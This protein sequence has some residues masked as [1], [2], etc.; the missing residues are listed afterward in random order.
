MITGVTGSLLS[1]AFLEAHVGAQNP[2]SPLVLRRALVAWH[3]R[4]ASL[5][6]ASSLRSMFESGARPLLRHLGYQQVS[7]IDPIDRGLAA[8]LHREARA[9]ALVVVA[10]GE[11]FDST[12]RLAI[13]EAWRRST[14]YALMF[15]GIRLRIVD[16]RQPLAHR[17]VELDLDAAIDDRQTLGVL[18][19]VARAGVLTESMDQL[20]EASDQHAAG[21]CRSL[22]DGVL[23]ASAHVLTALLERTPRRASIDEAYEQALTIVYRFLF[24]LFAEARALVPVW[25]AIYRESYTLGALARAAERPGGEEGLWDA[26]GAIARLARSGCHAGDLIVTPFNGR[27]FAA[28]H[29]PLAERRDLNDRLAQRAVIALTTRPRRGDGRERIAY[30][31]LGV[32]QLGAVYETLLD[33]RPSLDRSAPGLHSGSA[34]S[35]RSTAT[36]SMVRGSTARKSTGSFYTPQSLADHLVARTLRPLVHDAPARRILELRVV[37]PAMGSGAFLVAACRYLASAYEAALVREGSCL[38]SD[39]DEPH[40]A[41][42]RRIVVERCLYGVDLNPMAV[43]LARLSLWLATLSADRPLSFL[44]HRLHVGDSLVGAWLS[45]LGRKPGGKTRAAPEP[46]PLFESEHVRSVMLEVLPARFSL[47]STPNDTV[48]QVH[49]KE[50]LLGSIERHGVLSKWARIADLW[51]ASWLHPAAAIPPAAFHELAEVVLHGRSALPKRVAEQYLTAAADAARAGR[52]FH[53][54]LRCP[55][56]FFDAEGRRRSDG[57]FDAVIGNPPWDVVRADLGSRDERSHARSRAD[58]FLRFVRGSGSYDAS[59]GHPNRYQLFLE[60]AMALAR[61]GGRI[62]LVLPSGLATD[63]GSA[64]LR[65][66]LFRQCAV[67]EILGLDNRRGVFPIHRGISFLLLTAS[68]GEPTTSMA[69]RFGLDDP[70]ALVSVD[71]PRQRP[72]GTVTLTPALIRRLTGEALTIPLWRTPLDLQIAERAA[73]IFPSLGG[74]AGWNARFGRELNATEDRPLFGPAGKGLPIVEGKLLEPFAVMVGS[75]SSSIAPATALRLLPDGRHLRPRLAYRDVA[76][77]TNK[78]TLIA[79]VLPAG[80]V[81]THTVFCLRTKLPLADQHFLCGLFNSF[82]LNFL[83]RSR[84]TTHVTTTTLERLPVPFLERGSPRR[85]EIAALARLL[86]RRFDERSYVR[87]QVLAAQL[88]QLSVPEFEHVL[89]TFPLVSADVRAA[90]SAMFRHEGTR[91]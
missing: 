3:R 88:Y 14:F 76:S 11:P 69:C 47:E 8:T 33:Y 45:Q 48:D 27:L 16:A 49:A 31:D 22:R 61:P 2:A 65:Q 75:S 91:V 81:S 30:R 28:Q 59:S 68:T 56:V 53:W 42:M 71:E 73:T 70:A 12:W 37:D 87:L 74:D 26:L 62:G 25:H 32:E 18:W 85:R 29:A 41:H 89:T 9:T 63:V 24:L 15:N 20:V 34:K 39:V 7:S 38:P 54:E 86:A 60:R 35:Q 78:L 72:V 57:G 77:A 36:V 64:S 90:A 23:A 66:R 84:V 46:L 4:A 58:Q 17:H 51:C 40:R 67:D 43:Q 1:E 19:S 52:F 55:E 50:R 82:V 13:K 83:V 6:P 5:G 79:A 10:W 80:C 44:D 21:V